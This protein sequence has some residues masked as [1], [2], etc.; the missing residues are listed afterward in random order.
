METQLS[1]DKAEQKKNWEK[2]VNTCEEGSVIT[3]RVRSKV[4]GGLVVNIGV[5]AFALISGRYPGSQKP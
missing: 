3:G 4:K 1:F 2:I 5:D